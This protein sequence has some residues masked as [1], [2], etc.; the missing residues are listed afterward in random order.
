MVGIIK[1]VV[2]VKVR[3]FSGAIH[4]KNGVDWFQGDFDVRSVVKRSVAL[5]L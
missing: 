3:N 5:V 1:A 4:V 2:A